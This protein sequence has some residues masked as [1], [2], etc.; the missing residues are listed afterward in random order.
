MV[1]A[2]K[3]LPWNFDVA[4]AYSPLPKTGASLLGGALSWAPLPGSA[5]LPALGVRASYTTVRGLDQL[6][7]STAGLD[8]SISK[9]FGPLTPYLGAGKVWSKSQATG[10]V[11]LAKENFSQTKVFGGVGVGAGPVNFIVEYDRTGG[12]NTWGAKLGLKF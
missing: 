10:S 1:R 3:G 7:F 11:M 6:D 8:A 2:A 12:I 9:G 5:V 4:V